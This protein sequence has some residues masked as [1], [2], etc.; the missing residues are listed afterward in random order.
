MLISGYCA[1]M[2]QSLLPSPPIFRAYPCRQPAIDMPCSQ[3]DARYRERPPRVLRYWRA[4]RAFFVRHTSIAKLTTSGLPSKM[5]RADIAEHFGSATRHRL[6]LLLDMKR[7]RISRVKPPFPAGRQ[8]I[9]T[10]AI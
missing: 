4:R 10:M 9:T 3:A 6:R 8:N 2:F 5:Q 7:R 1:E